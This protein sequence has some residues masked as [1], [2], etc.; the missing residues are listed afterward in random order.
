MYP[1]FKKLH[2]YALDISVDGNSIIL[3]RFLPYFNLSFFIKYIAR[4][5]GVK[6]E[7]LAFGELKK[8]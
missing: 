8:S 3:W 2:I 1:Y 7:N 4:N 6:T 5:A